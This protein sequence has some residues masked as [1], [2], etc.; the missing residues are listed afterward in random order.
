MKIQCVDDMGR[1]DVETGKTYSI[2]ADCF[3]HGDVKVGG[4]WRSL[5]YNALCSDYGVFKII[6]EDNHE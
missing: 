2:P 3:K 4:F 5:A 6:K 1:D